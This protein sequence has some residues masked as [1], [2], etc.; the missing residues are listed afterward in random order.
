LKNAD[1][2]GWAVQDAAQS[3]DILHL[4]DI[5]CIPF[6]TFVDVPA[7]LTIHHP[8][9]PTLSQF[10]ERYPDVHY[11]TIAHWLAR[12]ER[13]P[14]IHVVHHG[15][16]VDRYTFSAR[17]DDYV[18]FLGRMA[19]CKGPHLAIEAAR[20][21]GIPIKLAGEIQ[22]MFKD[23]WTREVEPL[24]DGKDV[25]YVGEADFRG[26]NELLSRARALLFPIQW[27]EPFGLVMIEAMACGTP[28][29]ARRCGSVEEIVDDGH[30]GFIGDTIED[31]VAAV[32]R[33]DA[34]SRSACRRR[35]EEQFSVSRMVDGYEAIYE[36]VI[37]RR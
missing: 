25:E 31:L 6:T 12:R 5:A 20:L 7:V 17:K 29:I 21:A 33:A 14:N 16:P 28:V 9:E 1:H 32:H 22:P 19:P 4:N 8:H 13:M 3:V 30:T 37:A 11:V 27:E 26:K 2:S 35:V 10:Y 23:Y 18:A 15:I 24:I 36:R 34:I